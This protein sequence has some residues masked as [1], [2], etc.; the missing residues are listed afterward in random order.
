MNEETQEQSLDKETTKPTAALL[1]AGLLAACQEKAGQPPTTE[2]GEVDIEAN[3][4]CGGPGAGPGPGPGPGPGAPAT[5]APPQVTVD[6]RQ[7]SVL[8]GP[9]VELGVT[10]MM[11]T[12]Q[13][14]SD[15]TALR[16][17]SFLPLGA[18]GGLAGFNSDRAVPA[19][20]LDFVQG[21]AATLSLSSMMPHSIHLHGLDVDQ[22][23]D[24][25]PSLSG[26]VGMATPMS[27]GRVNG[28][29]SLGTR[30]DYQFTP[31]H[32]GTFIYH[33]HVDT[34]L[35]LEM[36]MTGT[37]IVRP[38]DGSQTIAGQPY[39][40]EYLWQLQTFDSRWHRFNV[41]GP[42]LASYRPDYFLINGRD[43]AD[44]LDDASV[45]LQALPGQVILLRLVNLGYPTAEV[46][47]AGL[48]FQVVA[49][50]G[51]DLPEPL[52]V[53][54]LRIGAG[55][56]YDCLLSL[57]QGFAGEAAV[58]YLDMRGVSV[59]GQAVTSVLAL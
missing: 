19:P 8:E 21:Q 15:G 56:R 1:A 31:A 42:G 12:T 53:T 18:G 13:T 30:F 36:G 29:T 55:E 45:R 33:C 25:V 37:V 51:R 27:F 28:L 47:L 50:D 49:S 23:N 9:Q 41:S 43:G 14:L 17:W 57:P 39:D 5:P 38:A 10:P 40:V 44:L 22:A 46:T 54:R 48:E 11:N 58:D 32:A 7:F 59:L 52:P 34:V 16:V 35:H 24:G 20:C 3:C 26:F 2:E 4:A 6:G